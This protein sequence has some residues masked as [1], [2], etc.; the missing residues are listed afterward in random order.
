VEFEIVLLFG[1][2]F[3]CW[4][5]N[6]PHIDLV[7]S[8]KAALSSFNFV[9]GGSDIHGGKSW[10]EDLTQYNTMHTAHQPS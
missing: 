7:S 8:L 1:Q 9:L 4:L 3:P 2:I 5:T 6:K 10:T